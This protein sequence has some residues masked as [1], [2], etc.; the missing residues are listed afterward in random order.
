MGRLFHA[1]DNERPGSQMQKNQV[2]QLR[3]HAA[4][5][6]VRARKLPIRYSS[7]DLRQLAIGLLWLDRKGLAPKDQGR[8]D[9]LISSTRET[10]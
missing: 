9:E 6:L 7:N 2:S 1:D 10:A 5:A 4:N 3:M 8:V